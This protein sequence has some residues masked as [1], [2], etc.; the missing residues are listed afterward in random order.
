[1]DANRRR[2]E[3]NMSKRWFIG[4]AVLAIVFLIARSAA[5]S[6]TS[7]WETMLERMPDTAPPKWMFNNITAIRENTDR[8]LEQLG[9]QTT[10]TQPTVSV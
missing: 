1:M 3:E 6:G 8:I 9:Q 7:R 4:A 2:L 5:R 10:S